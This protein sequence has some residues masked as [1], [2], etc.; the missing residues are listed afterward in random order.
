MRHAAD[1]VGGSVGARAEASIEALRRTLDAVNEE[2]ARRAEEAAGTI[3]RATEGLG[4]DLTARVPTS[5][6]RSGPRAARSEISSPRKAEAA[7]TQLAKPDATSSSRPSPP[8][9]AGQRCA[10]PHR[11]TSRTPPRPRQDNDRVLN[12]RLAALQTPSPAA[13]FSPT[14]FPA[15][16]TALTETVSGRLEEMDRLITS[17]PRG[18]RNHHRAHPRAQ[19]LVE[20][21]LGASR[22]AVPAPLGRM[23]GETFAKLVAQIDGHL[24][25]RATALNEP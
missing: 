13:T 7:Q 16:T 12:D 9:S 4:G 21:Q 3:A 15:T 17:R 1:G 19:G 10:D 2:L 20:T 23:I 22:R 5:R 8:G 11:A 18:R 24:G 25:S 14:G 6:P